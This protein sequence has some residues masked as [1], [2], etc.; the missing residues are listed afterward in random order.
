MNLVQIAHIENDYTHK[1]GIPR[2]S[3]LVEEVVSAIV[4]DGPYGPAEALRG[5]S[6]YD[7]LWLIFGFSENHEKPFSATVKPPRLGGKKRMGV[8]ATRSPY[9]PNAIGLSSVRIRAIDLQAEGGPRIYVTGADL[10]NGSPIY[11]IK[12]YLEYSDSHVG[13][14][15]GFTDQ[16]CQPEIILTFPEELLHRMEEEKRP[17]AIALLKQD[18]R[19][20]Y[21]ISQRR[22]YRLAYGGY[23]IVFTA[24]GS[25]ITVNDVIPLDNAKKTDS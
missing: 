21:E 8:Y 3:G 20:G 17:G 11:D 13:V 23:D 18:P 12:P 7:Y 14:R 16:Y 2:Q 22:E 24:D 1:F 4:F 15:S 6:D 10:M 25:H 5:L 19:P 9:R